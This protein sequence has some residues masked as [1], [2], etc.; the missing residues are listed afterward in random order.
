MYDTKKWNWGF[1]VKRGITCYKHYRKLNLNIR[2]KSINSSKHKFVNT[3][4][5]SPS[6]SG[7]A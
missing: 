3:S 5:H 6:V 1:K 7:L 4:D 2:K